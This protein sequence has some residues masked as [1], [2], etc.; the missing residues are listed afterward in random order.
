MWEVS[1]RKWEEVVHDLRKEAKRARYNLE[2]FTKFYSDSYNRYVKEIKK[3]QTVI[4]EIQDCFVFRLFLNRALGDKWQNLAPKLASQ[5]REKR[6]QKW[7]EWEVLRDQ[8]LQPQTRQNFRK[9]V[10][11]PVKKL[12]HK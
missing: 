4:G 11:H 1:L 7:Q 12:K 6:Y 8:F 5:L 10:Q 3:I 9:T 2:L